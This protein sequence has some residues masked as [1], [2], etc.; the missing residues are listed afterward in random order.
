MFSRYSFSVQLNQRK[1]ALSKLSEPQ[2]IRLFYIISEHFSSL[3]NIRA[4]VRSGKDLLRK[5]QLS[6]LRIKVYRSRIRITPDCIGLPVRVYSGK[7]WKAFLV[8]KN[9]VGFPLNFFI[10]F[11]EL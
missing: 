11:F 4:V 8:K 3:G 1:K 5:S 7:A 6:L 9:I 2:R 10:L